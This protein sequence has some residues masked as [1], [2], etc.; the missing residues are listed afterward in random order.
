MFS[1]S[2]YIILAIWLVYMCLMLFSIFLL[3]VVYL[4]CFL[5]VI[6]IMINA[7]ECCLFLVSSCSDEL[8]S[9]LFNVVGL[10]AFNSVNQSATQSSVQRLPT[11]G[12]HQ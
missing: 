3:C 6:M 1:F 12:N 8:M 9:R 5:L 7:V 10:L 4:L 2:L 11:D